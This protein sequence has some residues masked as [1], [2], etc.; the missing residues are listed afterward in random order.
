MPLCAKPSQRALGCCVQPACRRELGITLQTF[1]P[2]FP[3]PPPLLDIHKKVDLSACFVGVLRAIFK[4]KLTGSGHDVSCNKEQFGNVR[5]NPRSGWNAFV[6][7]LISFKQRD[8]LKYQP[9][10]LLSPWK[11]W[12]LVCVGPSDSDRKCLQSHLSVWYWYHFLC[13]GTRIILGA[14]NTLVM[15]WAVLFWVQICLFYAC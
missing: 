7:C 2:G 3:I 5:S 13:K 9:A 8:G 11:N 12:E 14:L 1:S 15:A 4:I 10:F 6:S